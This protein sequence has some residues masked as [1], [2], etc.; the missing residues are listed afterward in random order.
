MSRAV[1]DLLDLRQAV[2]DALTAGMP[3]TVGVDVHGGDYDQDA[4]RRYAALAPCLRVAITGVGAGSRYPDGRWRMPVQLSVACFA[5]D[6]PAGDRKSIVGR[7]AAAL[8][9]AS[10]VT[11]IVQGNRFGLEGVQQPEGLDGRN[12]Y[13]GE[14]DARGVAIWQVIWASPVLLGA[15]MDEGIDG[16]D[17]ALGALTSLVVNGVANEPTGMIAGD[18][19]PRQGGAP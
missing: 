1:A 9:L 7:D 5:L 6:A 3:A 17:A 11:L 4:I 10:A 16:L 19:L 13:S 8:A 14:I 12:E 15:P 18:A 2:V